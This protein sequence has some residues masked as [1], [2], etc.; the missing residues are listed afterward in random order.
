M[1]TTKS[2]AYKDR[3]NTQN[4]SVANSKPDEDNS[5]NRSDYIPLLRFAPIVGS[6]FSYL[7]DLLGMQNVNDY[8]D[9]D[10]LQRQADN[11]GYVYSKPIGGY[12]EYQPTDTEY[13]Q[14]K[15]RQDAA[16]ARRSA[17]NASNGNRGYVST[18][19]AVNG[20]S[21]NETVGEIGQKARQADL[22]GR[23]AVARFNSN[24]DE[25]NSRNDLTVQ[26][27][28]QAIQAQRAQLYQNIAQLRTAERYANE[29]ARSNNE[30]DF[31]KNVGNLGKEIM[32]ARLANSNLG[33]YYGINWLT[34]DIYYKPAFYRKSKEEQEKIVKDGK[35]IGITATEEKED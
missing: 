21:L 9:A 28:N 20:Y 8:S 15:A 27:K 33:Q 7:R 26:E 18:S 6:G 22:E 3:S 31:Y 13:L 25:I 29:D 4:G 11:L 5:T 14:N 17:A 12:Q 32:A 16:A 10:T 35:K 30:S 2:G 1:Y 24:I 19:D 34:G 23:L